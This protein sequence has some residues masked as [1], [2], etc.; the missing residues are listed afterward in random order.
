MTEV[1]SLILQDLNDAQREAVTAPDGPLLV[2]AGAGSGKTRVLTRRIAYLLTERGAHPSEIFAVTFTNKAAGEMQRRVEELV[3]RHARGMWIHTF[4]SACARLLRAHPERVG[5]EPGFVIYDDADQQTLI[6][7]LL[8]KVELDPKKWP[9][10]QI[11]HWFDLAKNEAVSPAEHLPGAL[12][13]ER[14]RLLA[15][16]KLYERRVREANAFDFGDLIVEAIRLLRD[17]PEIG[18]SYRQRF[19]HLLVDEFQD[20]NRAQYLLL[21]QLLDEH[22]H[23]TVVGDDD[24][25]IYR[26]RGARLANILEFEKRFP[27][28]KVVILGTNYRSSARILRAADA[29]IRQNVGRQAKKM[30]TPNPAGAAVVRCQMD[31]EYS[32]AR[33]VATTIDELRL[34]QGLRAA[35]IAVFYRINAQSRMIEEKLIERGIPYI[36]VGGTRFYDRKE[37]KDAVAYLR[38]AVN[39][40]DGAAFARVVNVPPRGVGDRTIERLQEMAEQNG[41]S[42]VAVCARVGEGEGEGFSAKAR[43]ELR[44]FAGLFVREPL[45]IPETP[46]A[47]AARLLTD[48]RYLR[49]LEDSKKIEDKTRLENVRELLKSVEDFEKELGAEAELPLFLE[50]VSLLSDPDLYDE[51]AD[52]VA[53]MTLHSAKGLEFPAVFMVGVE[54]GLLPHSRSVS[55]PEQL[56]EERRL[57]YVGVTRAK[58][59]LFWTAAAMRS[60]FGGAPTP[61]RLSRFWFDLPPDTV[62]DIGPVRR[63]YRAA[64][65]SWPSAPPA[66]S[67]NEPV[68]DD[69]DSQDADVNV[70]IWKPGCRVRHPTF[71][72]GTLLQTTGHDEFTRATVAFDSGR[73]GVKTLV[74]KFANLSY[75]GPGRGGQ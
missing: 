20:T 49:V 36:V 30:D 37:I 74:L 70:S 54:E 26:W 64:A 57:C 29:L 45:P 17:N 59:R 51:R 16:A 18:A 41:V 68:Y 4:H 13:H 35:E 44:R 33:Y 15:L 46:S 72:R 9:P 55:D 19:R 71:G 22:R 7:E 75:E 3:G 5:R 53:L 56:E 65:Q 48:S 1:G 28:A 61:T 12:A 8:G 39:P 67:A 21:D 62:E 25:S 31:D 43:D 32:E 47:T 63:S 27:D 69:S 60:S 38:L 14:P 11:A 42:L 6:K 23:L 34:R 66:A 40:A 73:Y 52:A 50:K 10:R 24:Q 58:Q 2:F